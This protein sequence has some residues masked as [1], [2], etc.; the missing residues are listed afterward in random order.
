MAGPLIP[1][2][3][4]IACGARWSSSPSPSIDFCSPST[5]ATTDWCGGDGRR[6]SPADKRTMDLPARK[7]R[8]RSGQR[9]RGHGAG[10]A[11]RPHRAGC[12]PR[13]PQS[14][15]SHQTHNDTTTTGGARDDVSP[16]LGRAAV[17]LGTDKSPPMFIYYASALGGRV[18]R[19][20]SG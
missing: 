13:G 20:P 14:R 3:T 10:P 19:W 15:L 2:R 9:G 1:E 8:V 4:K 12:A 7:R 17:Q 16:T 5:R 6:G 18:A 11:S